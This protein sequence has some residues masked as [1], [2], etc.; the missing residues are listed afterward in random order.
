MDTERNSRSRLRVGTSLSRA[1]ALHLALMSSENRA[2]HALGRTFP[3]GLSAFVEAMNARARLLG[4]EQTTFVDPT[5][6]SNRN[7]SSVRDVA[8]LAA[9]AAKHPVLR[10][11]ST[12]PLRRVEFDGRKLLYR[13]SNRLI[14]NSSWEIAL[15]KT[16]YIIEAGQCLEMATR[17]GERE[18]IL[19]LLDSASKGSRSADAERLRRW[20]VAQDGGDPAQ[21]ARA[22]QATRVAGAG[23]AARAKARQVAKGPQKKT[24]VAKAAQKKTTQVAKSSRQKGKAVAQSQ[25]VRKTYVAGARKGDQS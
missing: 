24:Q 1:E 12:T 15:Q 18:V 19:V 3:G 7:Q 25:R 4:M 21:Y 22:A 5:G 10:E 11:Y 2:A 20:V 23:K 13:N 6:L 9:A 17:L 16:G 14:M 8:T